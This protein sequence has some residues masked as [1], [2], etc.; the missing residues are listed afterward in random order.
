M[1]RSVKYASYKETYWPGWEVVLH[2]HVHILES[3]VKVCVCAVEKGER[4]RE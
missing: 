4:E 1:C 2:M 3:I